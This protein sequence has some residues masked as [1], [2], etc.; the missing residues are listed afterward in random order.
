MDEWSSWKG[1]A[2]VPVDPA[3]VRSVNLMQYE[4]AISRN[5]EAVAEG[6]V[7]VE[8]DALNFVISIC[9]GESSISI[10]HNDITK[11]K[12]TAIVSAANGNLRNGG[13]VAAA[14]CKAAGGRVF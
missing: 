5:G 9:G 2:D 14:I 11:E 7:K 12:T 13:G 4:L 3:L 10:V 1:D 8:V 6:Q